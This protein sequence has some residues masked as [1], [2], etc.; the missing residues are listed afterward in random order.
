M[1]NENAVIYA[2]Y[3]SNN[4]QE[5]SI[6][7]QIA[8]A[9]KYALDKGYTIIQEYCDR[10]KTGTNDNREAFQRMLRDC[11]K[12]QFSVIICWKVD[13]FGR[14]REEIMYNKYRAKKC[15]VR[16]EYV[17]ENIGS[18]PEGVILES[19]FEGMAEYFSI[20]LSQN[21]K[22]GL[23][24]NAKQHKAV[25]GVVPLGY[26]L[27]ADKHFEIDPDTAPIVKLIFQKYAD[28]ETLFD[29]INYL[30]ASGYKT[31]KGN[32][33]GKS[34]LAKMLRNEKY[35]GTYVYKD[36]I[37]DEDVIPAIIDKKTFAKVQDMLDTNKRK[38]AGSWTFTDYSLTG[39]LFCGK[40]GAPM[41]GKAG[42]SKN[43]ERY[44]YYSC[45]NHHTNK[46]CDK[47]A[48]RQDWI[49]PTVL[50]CVMDLLHDPDLFND[51]IERTWSYYESQDSVKSE[52][53]SIEA[54]LED[55]DKRIAN[56]MRALEKAPDLDMIIDRI[57]ELKKQKEEIQQELAN[58]RIESGIGFSKDHIIYFMEKCRDMD[59]STI[60]DQKVLIKT[61]VNSI[62]LY[63]DHMTIAFNYSGDQNTITIKDIKKADKCE[64]FASVHKSVG[65]W[66][67]CEH[68]MIK[69]IKKV[70]IVDYPLKK[71]D[72]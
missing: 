12:K 46:S 57:N 4:Q 25:S 50:S 18:G 45:S 41:V 13:R 58:K 63:D 1:T 61:F 20:Q 31:S 14:N 47:S 22:R 29:I 10:A 67:L 59:I 34:S 11:E 48:V 15:G 35:I 62:F 64:V 56:L 6:E 8:A 44:S 36:I 65:Q 9:K 55:T 51:I 2:R 60:E 5:T 71:R 32:S 54:N 21:V 17:A 26:R 23:L 69:W 7:G 19:L 33:Y 52:I 16:V 37:R 72:R 66:T 27:T 68:L 39:K 53:E 3:S 43:G 49:E 30:N 38:P 42:T 24:E 40:C 28:G 70:L